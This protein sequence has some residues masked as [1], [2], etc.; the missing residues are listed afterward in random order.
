MHAVGKECKII[1]FPLAKAY[2][3]SGGPTPTARAAPWCLRIAR[4][5]K[6]FRIFGK[7]LL[8]GAA[9]AA[10]AAPAAATAALSVTFWD[11]SL[12]ALGLCSRMEGQQ[13]QPHCVVGLLLL[14]SDPTKTEV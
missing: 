4:F 12:P 1:P 7:D 10:A 2:A 3:V 5:S 6:E 14:L 13:Q 11:C 8:S 9:R